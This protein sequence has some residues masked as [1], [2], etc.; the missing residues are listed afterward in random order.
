MIHRL[1][2]TVHD[3][4]QRGPRYAVSYLGEQIVEASVV[5]LLDACRVLKDMG[6]TGPVEMWGMQPYPRMRTTVEAGAKLTVAEGQRTSPRLVPYREWAEPSRGGA[7][8][9]DAE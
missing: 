9:A 3:H 1:D 6:L 5:P 4:G 7:T 2:I 8:E